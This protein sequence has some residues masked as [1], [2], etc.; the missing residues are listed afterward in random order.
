MAARTRVQNGAPKKP[1]RKVFRSNSL[2][3]TQSLQLLGRAIVE[4]YE[5]SRHAILLHPREPVPNCTVTMVPS[6]SGYFIHYTAI[7][8]HLNPDGLPA[9]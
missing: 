9:G 5:Q 1:G 2:G 4:L 3:A 7:Y 8:G 6:P